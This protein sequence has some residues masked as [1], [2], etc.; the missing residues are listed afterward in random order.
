MNCSVDGCAKEAARGGLCWGHIKRRQ[1]KRTVS[2]ELRAWGRPP[3][4]LLVDAALSVADADTADDGA[5]RRA[6]DLLR[7]ASDRSR[8][9]RKPR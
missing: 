7:K 5:W 4:Q 1:R 8:Q 6:K 9:R 2:G 3:P